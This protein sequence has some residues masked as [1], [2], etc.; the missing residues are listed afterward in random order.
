[1][2]YRIGQPCYWCRRPMT[3]KPMPYGRASGT[4]ATVDHLVPRKMGGGN[5]Q[6]NRVFA[7]RRCNS[8]KGHMMPH[9]FLAFMKA[10]PD[11]FT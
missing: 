11:K 7:C 6:R 8:H 5:L 2:N 3:E 9:E 4:A 1:M 10:N